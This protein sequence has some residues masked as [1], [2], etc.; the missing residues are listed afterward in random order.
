MDSSAVSNAAGAHGTGNLLSA[1]IYLN[2]AI[3]S[4]GNFLV[5]VVLVRTLGLEQFGQYSLLFV[6]LLLLSATH[7]ALFSAPM[8]TIAPSLPKSGRPG[9]YANLNL[10]QVAL[11]LTFFVAV[12]PIM[13]CVG[14]W[15]EVASAV[16]WPLAAASAC[17]PL[18]EWQRRYLVS[19][20][21]LVR[22]VVYDGLRL[23]IWLLALASLY[24]SDRL[25]VAT[26]LL[27][28]A[29]SSGLVYVLGIFDANPRLSCSHAIQTARKNWAHA[30]H[31]LPAYQLE[32][33]GLQGFLIV[34]GVMLGAQL[35]GAIRAAQNILGP[36]NIAY[37]AADSIYPARGARALAMHGRDALRAYFLRSARIGI[38]ALALLC[39]LVALFSADIIRIAYGPELVEHASLVIW[40]AISLVLGYTFKLL[41]AYLRVVGNTRKVLMAT[42]VGVVAAYLFIYPLGLQW[43]ADGIMLAKVSAE[44]LAIGFV[45]YALASR[46]QG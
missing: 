15:W 35:A 14:T 17:V 10:L 3:V 12:P 28:L 26:A 45:G 16:A 4:G 18:Q 33:A 1:P 38:P 2:Q 22:A 21:Q 42:L 37:Q 24:V 6:A 46:Q 13:F 5:A 44:C 41:T 9:Y 23:T 19:T 40:Q 8:F 20:R 30:R 7:N 34:A 11:C 31:L 29:L 27:A 25:S 36:L 32:W 43:S 39:F